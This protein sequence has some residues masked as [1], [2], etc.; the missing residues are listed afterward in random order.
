MRHPTCAR[1]LGKCCKKIQ[2]SKSTFSQH[3]FPSC[4]PKTGCSKAA[5]AKP[6]TLLKLF[7]DFA[8][9]STCTSQCTSIY[10][11]PEMARPSMALLYFLILRWQRWFAT[12]LQ[13]LLLFGLGGI[14]QG[15]WLHRIAHNTEETLLQLSSQT[16]AFMGAI[17]T[18]W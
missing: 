13:T 16:N 1:K 8:H 6:S 2:V 14:T 4:D 10:I 17:Y 15:V 11:S 5:L 12:P 18:T 3:G 7:W 9:L